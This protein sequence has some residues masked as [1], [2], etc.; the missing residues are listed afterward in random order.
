MIF[1]DEVLVMLKEKQERLEK[2][3]QLTIFDKIEDYDNVT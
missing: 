1:L 3:K 2:T